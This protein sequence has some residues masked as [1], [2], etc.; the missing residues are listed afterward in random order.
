MI[1]TQHG[2][3]HFRLGLHVEYAD[4]SYLTSPRSFTSPIYLSVPGRFLSRLHPSVAVLACVAITNFPTKRTKSSP[5]TMP[6]ERSSSES[7]PRDSNGIRKKMRK[8]THSCFECELS[9]CLP[10]L[11]RLLI[12]CCL[13]SHLYH[14]ILIT[15]RGGISAAVIT[16]LQSLIHVLSLPLL[17]PPQHLAAEQ[18]SLMRCMYA[19]ALMPFILSS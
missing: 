17:K 16:M 12:G 1:I 6:P 8:G 7:G 14:C 19:F 18:L 2:C 11:R 5:N 10:R 9:A 3:L 4:F 13:L 15:V